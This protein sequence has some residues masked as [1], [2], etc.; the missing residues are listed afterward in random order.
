MSPSAV[1]DL[2]Q[3]LESLLS[4]S[5]TPSKQKENI[6]AKASE[7]LANAEHLETNYDIFMDH[8]AF[9]VTSN[10]KPPGNDSLNDAWI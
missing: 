5:P 2:D 9:K 10:T 7:A 3:D 1:S 6:T 4:F 8:A